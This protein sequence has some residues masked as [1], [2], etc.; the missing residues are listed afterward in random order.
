MQSTTMLTQYWHSQRL[1][2]HMSAQ[3]LTS[4]AWCQRSQQTKFAVTFILSFGFCKRKIIYCTLCQHCCFSQIS[5]Q[6]CFCLFKWT[7]VEFFILNNFK[8][9]CNTVSFS[10]VLCVCVSALGISMHGKQILYCALTSPFLVTSSE[11][12][13]EL[14]EE[15]SIHECQLVRWFS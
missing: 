13:I 15:Q 8:K 1:F 3:S 12:T 14:C 9:S 5:S 11:Q 7:Q 2:R 6:N 4:A 10:F